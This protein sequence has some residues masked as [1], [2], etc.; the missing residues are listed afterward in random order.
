M[1]DTPHHTTSS[2]ASIPPEPPR[3]THYESIDA[4]TA[5][6]ERRFGPSKLDW[7]FVCPGCGH[8]QRPID[9]R[10]YKDAGA[11]AETSYKVCIG[12]YGGLKRDWLQ[13]EGEGPCNYT[14]FGLL[15]INPVTV[16]IEDGQMISIFDFAP[17]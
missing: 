8:R 3:K 15:N 13:G 12:R 9:F 14:S 2:P 4:W 7:V 6:G 16:A 5:E 10:P 11:T 1:S 17:V